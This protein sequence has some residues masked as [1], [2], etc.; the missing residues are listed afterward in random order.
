MVTTLTFAIFQRTHT[1]H[2]AAQLRMVKTDGRIIINIFPG[3]ITILNRLET[4][5]R[6]CLADQV[7]APGVPRLKHL[8]VRRFRPFFNDTE[9]Y[10][11]IVIRRTCRISSFLPRKTDL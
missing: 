3:Q 7:S 8:Y 4:A 9:E 2:I 11:G 6:R 5:F 10:Y 1:I